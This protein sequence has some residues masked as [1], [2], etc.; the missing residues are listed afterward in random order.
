M[1]GNEHCSPSCSKTDLLVTRNGFVIRFQGLSVKAAVIVDLE[2][3]DYEEDDHMS[4]RSFYWTVVSKKN[5]PHLVMLEFCFFML[6]QVC[7]VDLKSNLRDQQVK[8]H[9]FKFFIDFRPFLAPVGP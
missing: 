9:F 2:A 3:H 8:H 7:G 1:L 4:L 5:T 6:Y